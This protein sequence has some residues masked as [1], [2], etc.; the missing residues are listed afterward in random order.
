MVASCY[1]LLVGTLLVSA[2]TST[3][4]RQQRPLQPQA[5]GNPY[6]DDTFDGFVHTCLETAKVPGLSIAVVDGDDVYA[7][8]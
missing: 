2:A 4:P 6:L 3:P 8:V 7:K 1:T 5:D